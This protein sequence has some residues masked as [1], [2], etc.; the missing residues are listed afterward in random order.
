M[1]IFKPCE[2][3]ISLYRSPFSF[4]GPVKRMLTEGIFLATFNLQLA[5]LFFGGGDGERGKEQ[6]ITG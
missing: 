2:E 5:V 3:T 6:L 1:L 4:L